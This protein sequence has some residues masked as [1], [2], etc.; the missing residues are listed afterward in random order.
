MKEWSPVTMYIIG[1]QK[2]YLSPTK[3]L[4]GTVDITVHEVKQDGTLSE[5]YKASG[6]S[7]GGTYVDKAFK[8]FLTDIVGNDVMQAFIEEQTLDYIDLFRNFEVKKRGFKGHA[9][10]RVVF[11]VPV[12]MNDTFFAKRNKNIK[13]VLQSTKFADKVILF[14]SL[15]NNIVII[16]I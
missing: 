12:S 4:G 10:D 6:G 14:K 13:D 7:W 8:D 9:T 15:A 11:K 16:L 3:L 1:D 2:I 5:I